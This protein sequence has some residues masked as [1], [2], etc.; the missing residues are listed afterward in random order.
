MFPF[1]VLRVTL[2]RTLRLSNF[3]HKTRNVIEFMKRMF[4]CV[5]VL[6]VL[7][8]VLNALHVLY[9]ILELQFSNELFD[10]QVLKLFDL[11]FS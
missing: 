2:L 5:Y 11:C 10:A 9:E 6:Y 4:I 1:L 8:D 7:H 3:I